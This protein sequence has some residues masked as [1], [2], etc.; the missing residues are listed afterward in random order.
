MGVPTLAGPCVH[1]VLRCTEV[2]GVVGFD[3]IP[4]RGVPGGP[5][6]PADRG[7]ERCGRPALPRPATSPQGPGGCRIAIR[8]CDI[9]PAARDIRH[10]IRSDLTCAA[11]DHPIPRPKNSHRTT[12]TVPGPTEGK[13]TSPEALGRLGFPRR[14]RTADTCPP[15]RPPPQ[16]GRRQ[17]AL[18]P[19]GCRH[20][21]GGPFTSAERRRSCGSRSSKH[22]R[23][24]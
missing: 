9:R 6:V 7:T 18:D 1:R 11:L 17:D 23:S 21:A 8:A 2:A 10:A 16:Y 15:T 14:S 13:R 5:F 24:N 12:T 19:C 4:C 20:A 3:E 22:D